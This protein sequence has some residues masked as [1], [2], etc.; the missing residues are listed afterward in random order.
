MPKQIFLIGFMGTGKTF[1][2]EKLA[3]QLSLDFYDLDFEIE[4]KAGLDVNNIFALKG[5]EFFREIEA[6][7][8]Q[9]WNQPGVIATG[10]GVVLKKENR[11]MLKKSANQVIWLNP[12]WEIIRSRIVNSYRPL[13]LNR[14]EME[15]YMLWSERLPFYRECAQVIFEGT[16]LQDLIALLPSS[17]F[18]SSSDSTSASS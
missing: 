14:S 6:E 12:R 7:V 2:G 17:A 1:L 3:E 4:K 13:V 8:L 15:L 18:P 9:N 5:E 11:D 16:E 10:G